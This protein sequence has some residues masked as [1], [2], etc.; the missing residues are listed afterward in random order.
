M[1]D[2]KYCLKCS[3]TSGSGTIVAISDPYDVKIVSA[4]A[5]AAD[6][7]MLGS[8]DTVDTYHITMTDVIKDS[9]T[10]IPSIGLS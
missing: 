4:G 3:F 8:V 1:G 7:T 9:T 6:C 10:S 2:H 5:P